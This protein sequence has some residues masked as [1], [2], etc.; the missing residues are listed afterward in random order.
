MAWPTRRKAK[1]RLKEAQP[2][3]LRR[4]VDMVD[5][6]TNQIHL[7]AAD[8]AAAGRK[9]DGR[10]RALCGADVLP[11]AL[12]EPGKGYCWLCRTPRSPAQ[13]SRTSR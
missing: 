1:H 5:L 3:G 13:R 7:L 2:P 8:A 12:V 9:A 6:H 4:T 11:A 10:Y